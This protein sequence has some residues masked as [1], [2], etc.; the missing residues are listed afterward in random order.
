MPV[1]P[2]PWCGRCWPCRSTSAAATPA[3]MARWLARELAPRLPQAGDVDLDMESRLILGHGGT[4]PGRT[5]AARGVGRAGLPGRSGVCRTAPDAG[6]QR[7]TGRLHRR[8]RAGPAIGSRALVAAAGPADAVRRP[9]SGSLTGAA[10]ALTALTVTYARP[11]EPSVGDVLPPGVPVPKR[12]LDV[13]VKTAAEAQQ[14]APA[15]RRRSARR[16]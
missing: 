15:P 8:P 14:L 10:A 16:V 5:R 7:Q 12:A 4:E 1:A 3:A 13:I 6:G 9:A 11:L 2:G